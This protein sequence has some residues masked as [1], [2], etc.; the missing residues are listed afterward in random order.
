M[1]YL[2]LYLLL[3]ISCFPTA[4]VHSQN[5]VIMGI[6][7]D[8]N[9]SV[10]SNKEQLISDYHSNE[11]FSPTTSHPEGLWYSNSFTLDTYWFNKKMVISAGVNS[12]RMKS[13][14]DSVNSPVATGL[15]YGQQ[16]V[17]R[18]FIMP[19]IG[20]AYR[21]PISEHL[22][23]ESS[24]SF[25]APGIMDWYK[26]SGVSYTQEGQIS[27]N[28]YN[29]IY[30]D[31]VWDVYVDKKTLFLE[32]GQQLSYEMD[33]WSLSTGV[34]YFFMRNWSINGYHGLH[35]NVGCSV[36][37]GKSTPKSEL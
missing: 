31:G 13:V 14:S 32:L 24:L 20:I 5:K 11:D 33:R 4:E 27:W 35:F 12:F 2:A 28:N 19:K 18:T 3:I 29:T 8:H 21:H 9:F 26:S 34:N 25:G 15:Y 23:L 7:L 17:K 37:F 16:T 36:R 30:G 1:R 6:S 10:L 22:Y